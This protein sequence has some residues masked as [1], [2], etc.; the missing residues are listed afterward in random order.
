MKNKFLNI[1]IKFDKILAAMA[2]MFT[3]A[4][5]NSACLFITNQPKMPEKA[6]ELRKF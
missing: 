2:M 1:G 3:I 4:N 6:K 5:I